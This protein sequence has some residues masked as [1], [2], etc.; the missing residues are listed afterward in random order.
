[1]TRS[2]R[3]ASLAQWIVLGVVV[4]VVCGGGSAVFLLLLARGATD[5]RE[6]H[7]V[8]IYFLPLAGLVV[9]WLYERFG[10]SIRAGNNLVIDHDSRRGARDSRSHGTDGAHRHGAHA[11]FGGSAGREGTAV[12]MGASLTDWLSH[13]LGLS[14]PLRRPAARG[15]SRGRLRLGLR[16]SRRGRRV[17]SRVHRARP[18]SNTTRSCRRS[19]RRSSAT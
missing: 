4:G 16:H 5:F 10:D 8:I 17:R 15:R 3:F 9:G 7:E 13:R 12:Q 18:A 19:S 11:L 6:H 1:M 14:G 2:E